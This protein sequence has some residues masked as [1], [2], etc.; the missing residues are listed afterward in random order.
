MTTVHNTPGNDK[1]GGNKN[2]K[3][4]NTGITMVDHDQLFFTLSGLKDNL[5]MFNN[6]VM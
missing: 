5:K 2:T 6:N 3:N 4:A 1:N